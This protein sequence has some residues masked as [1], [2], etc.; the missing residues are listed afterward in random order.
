MLPEAYLWV[1]AIPV[2]ANGKRDQRALGQLAA[3]QLASGRPYLAARNALE[4]HLVE[5]FQQVLGQGRV[6]VE[7]DFFALGGHSLKAVQVVSLVY[8]RLQL[9]LSL[10]TLFNH[11]RVS[12][13][14]QVL[15]Q[16]QPQPY[17]P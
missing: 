13:L 11:S 14:A 2:T 15:D 5:I 6:G 12:A 7:D 4:Q 3:S 8:Q 1:E 10:S 17:Q 9:S 16:Q